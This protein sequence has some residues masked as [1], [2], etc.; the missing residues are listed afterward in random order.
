MLS[1]THWNR[2]RLATNECWPR[3]WMHLL[4][5]KKELLLFP[6]GVRISLFV[7]QIS[8]NSRLE[9][10]LN[11]TRYSTKNVVEKQTLTFSWAIGRS[12]ALLEL[13]VQTSWNRSYRYN[14]NAAVSS[15]VR[16][17]LAT[18][19]VWRVTRSLQWDICRSFISIIVICYVREICQ[20]SGRHLNSTKRSYL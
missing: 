11:L 5:E 6:M 8:W 17:L 3:A 7:E 12:V 13:S 14:R 20:C 15:L 9:N 16:P 10:L 19:G 1:L 2:Q 18:V 4:D